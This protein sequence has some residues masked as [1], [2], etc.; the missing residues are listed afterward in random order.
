MADETG[1]VFGEKAT[2]QIA[3]TVRE[4]MRR[5]MN[6]RG[7]RG[8][9][10]FHGGDSVNTAYATISAS[11][12][13]D[14]FQVVDL[15]RKAIPATF[16]TTSCGSTDFDD[17]EFT[18]SELIETGVTVL[19]PAGYK[20]GEALLVKWNIGTTE[21]LWSGWAVVVGPTWRCA[22]RIPV[23]VEC[24]PTTQLIKFTEFYNFWFF[25]KSTGTTTDPC[26]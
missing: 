11:D 16:T 26:P 22:T 3:K 13:D 15:Y 10:Q 2:E 25:G 23:D 20:G 19:V 21:H 4:D 9:W 17:M 24:C 12:E 8:R 7:N 1:T 6:V 18:L 5:M 14:E